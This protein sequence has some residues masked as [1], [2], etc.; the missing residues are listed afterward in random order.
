PTYTLS[1]HDAL[2]IC[3]LPNVRRLL[4]AR[5]TA[6][7]MQGSSHGTRTQAEDH[8][9]S[10]RITSDL[11]CPPGERPSGAAGEGRDPPQSDRPPAL[12]DRKSTRLNSSHVK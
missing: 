7:L 11:R 1:L 4:S 5:E 9:E 10:S 8:D 2:P 12:R 3:L 6:R